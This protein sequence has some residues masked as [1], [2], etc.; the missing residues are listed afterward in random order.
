MHHN[1]EQL[2]NRFAK[3]NP[4]LLFLRMLHIGL[5]EQ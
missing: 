2:L 1:E 5:N 3:S 4:P